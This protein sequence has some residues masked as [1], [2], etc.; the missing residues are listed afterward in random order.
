MNFLLVRFS[1]S[2]WSQFL[3]GSPVLGFSHSSCWVTSP[4]HGLFQLC[5]LPFSPRQR[6]NVPF[7]YLAMGFVQRGLMGSPTV[8]R[9]WFPP[10]QCVVLNW[11]VSR[12]SWL[13]TGQPQGST[14]R[15][16]TEVLCPFV[17]GKT[18]SSQ[19]LAALFVQFSALHYCWWDCRQTKAERYVQ[20]VSNWSFCVCVYYG[21]SRYS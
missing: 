20:A 13:K 16:Q 21:R 19:M 15:W 1:V 17:F 6:G 9:M 2:A 11:H 10:K 18:C 8:P 3:Q 5:I 7:M 12:Y 14:G 4:I